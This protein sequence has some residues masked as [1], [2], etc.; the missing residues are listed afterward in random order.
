MPKGVIFFS[1]VDAVTKEGI[2]RIL[3]IPEVTLPIEY[4]GVPLDFFLIKI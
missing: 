3:P 2:P 4:L 1:G